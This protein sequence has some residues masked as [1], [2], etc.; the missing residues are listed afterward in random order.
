MHS[1]DNISPKLR[2]LIIRNTVY[3]LIEQKGM[4]FDYNFGY[5]FPLF[6]SF[7]KKEGRENENK[8]AKIVIKRHAFLLDLINSSAF[9]SGLVSKRPGSAG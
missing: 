5:Y 8:V 6:S 4:T 2:N 3:K 9:S 7:L 1:F